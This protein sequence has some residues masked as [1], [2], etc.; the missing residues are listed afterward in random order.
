M[1]GESKC[2]VSDS[3]RGAAPPEWEFGFAGSHSDL[4]GSLGRFSVCNF[5][6]LIFPSPHVRG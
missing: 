1:A 3:E 2:G 5:N 6:L 4:S